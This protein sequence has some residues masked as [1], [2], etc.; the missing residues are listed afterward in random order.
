MTTG[1]ACGLF[2]D[3]SRRLGISFSPFYR[4]HL[5]SPWGVVL[6]GGIYLAPDGN[7]EN[8]GTLQAPLRTPA[9]AIRRQADVVI[10]RGGTYR[11]DRPLVFGADQSDQT[12]K[13]YGDEVPVLSG[14]VPVSGWRADA[15]GRFKAS[16]E[17]ENFRQLWVNGR[18]AKRARGEVPDG[19]ELWGA[20]EATVKQGANP[21]GLSGTP[22]YSPRGA[23][24]HRGGGVHDPR[25]FYRRVGEPRRHRVWLLQILDAHDRQGQ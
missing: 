14:G 23:R 10:L 5:D 3:Q 18:R 7:D 24:E 2:D 21:P 13:A 22:G 9:E 15:D 19:L 4:Y 12:W 1:Q 16:L 6:R 20:H 11:L 25:N 8:P 17:L